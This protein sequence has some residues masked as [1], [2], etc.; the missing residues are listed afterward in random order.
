MLGGVGAV[1]GLTFSF[2]LPARAAAPAPGPIPGWFNTTFG[3]TTQGS[4]TIDGNGVITIMGAGADTWERN[5]EFHILYKPLTGDGSVTTKMLSAEDGH[6]ASKIGVIMRNDLTDP[7]AAVMHLCMTTSGGG[8]QIHRGVAGEEM[9]MDFKSAKGDYQ[10]F[11]KNYPVWLKIERRGDRC[12]QYASSDGALWIPVTR[13]L[14]INFTK[15]EIVAGLFV[16]SHV[17]DTLLTGTF[18]SKFTDVSNKLLKPE[19]ATPLQPSPVIVE[20]G[21]NSVLLVWDRVDHLGHM[22]DGYVVYKAAVGSTDFTKIA[23]LPGDKTSYLDTSIKN[24]EMAQYRVTTVVKLGGKSV[25]TRDFGDTL[26][27]V[28]GSPNPPIKIGNRDYFANVLEGGAPQPDTTTPGSA[29]INGSGVVTLKASG[30]A[31]EDRNDG[32]EELLTPVTGDFTFTARVLGIPTQID[33]SDANES[34]KFGIAVREDTMSNSRYAGMLIT[35]QHGI[36]SPHRRLFD[37]ARSLDAGPSEQTPA[38]P[39]YF[40]LQRHGD[41]IRMFTSTDGQTYKAYGSPDTSI[42]PGL[43]P[44]VYVGL[45]GSSNDNDQVAQAKFDKIELTTP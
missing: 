15:N 12:Y 40:R 35:P 10:I 28:T 20:G 11:P 19:E 30:W 1:I 24:G 9:S 31:I 34:A 44:N 5:D 26:Y 39:V 2:L 38:F 37:T 18:D 41:E 8:Q 6:S 42:L 45:I 7:A 17:T 23:D 29:D 22:A 43:S 21:D 16:M 32:G 25:E 27:A 3:N 13:P 4:A 36:R 33:G 14:Q